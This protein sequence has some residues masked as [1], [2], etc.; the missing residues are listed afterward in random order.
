MTCIAVSSTL[1][2]KYLLQADRVVSNII[3]IQEILEKGGL[4]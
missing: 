4:R 1:G 3:N 2:K